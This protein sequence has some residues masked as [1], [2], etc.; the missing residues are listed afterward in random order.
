MLSGRTQR[1]GLPRHQRKE[2]EIYIK[3]NISSP[4]VGIEPTT[5]QFYSHTLC[6]CATPG[7]Y[8]T[9]LILYLLDI[10]LPSSL[11]YILKK[12]NIVF[13]NTY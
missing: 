5:S 13:D 12:P 10:F 1:R 6:R 7:L 4:R 8:R 3:V 2:M 11:F 9:I